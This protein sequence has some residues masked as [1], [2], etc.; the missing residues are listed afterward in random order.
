MSLTQAKDRLLKS[1]GIA[2]KTELELF[3]RLRDVGRDVVLLKEEIASA[4]FPIKKWMRENL[5]RS[6][7]WL[8]NHVR[9]YA[10]WDRFLKCLQWADDVHYPRN[11]H[12]SLMVAL[13]S[14][15]RL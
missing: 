13:R 9:L 12:P 14:Y 4:G 7:E 1:I 15:G 11:E 2:Q 8:Q 5:P 3:E 6:Y 10:E